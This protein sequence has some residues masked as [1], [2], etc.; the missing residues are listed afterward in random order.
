MAGQ[1]RIDE[2]QSAP[3]TPDMAES[4]FCKEKIV[5][6]AEAKI[7]S[8]YRLE[9]QRWVQNKPLKDVLYPIRKVAGRDAGL[10][11]AG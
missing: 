5:N 6:S 7:A 9:I 10:T 4:L 11:V 1:S 2:N 3:P 8:F